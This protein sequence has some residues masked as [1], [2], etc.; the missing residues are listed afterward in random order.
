MQKVMSQLRVTSVIRALFLTLTYPAK[1]PD[2]K[3]AKRDLDV[4][5]K[6][7]ARAYPEVAGIWRIEAQKRGAPHF[8]LVLL[9]VEHI[10]HGWVA[11]AWYEVVASG[12]AR[13]LQAGTEV[14]RV[15]SYQHA[16]HYVSKYLSKEAA[17]GG[18]A[19]DGLGEVGRR[20]GHFGNWRAHLGEFV[21]FALTHKEAARL[22]R[23]LDARRLSV[24]R[25][26]VK[27]RAAAVRCARDRQGLRFSRFYFGSPDFVLH[28][29]MQIIGRGG[30][31]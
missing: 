15:K 1:F 27:G 3:R 25:L 5:L 22:S 31:L 2:G 26:R 6:R 10:P 30:G 12:D 21:S 14:R 28:R 19:D 13:H 29:I 8:H 7:L 4:F 23:V 24:A 20:W 16:V 11:K 9:G 17:A 18:G